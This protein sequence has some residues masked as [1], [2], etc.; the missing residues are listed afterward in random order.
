MG[1]AVGP[2]EGIR[3]GRSVGVAE[4]NRFRMLVGGSVVGNPTGENDGLREGETNIE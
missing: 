1:C 3:V 4:G 2:A